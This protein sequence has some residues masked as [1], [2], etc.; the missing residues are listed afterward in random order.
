M[1]TKMRR[2]WRRSRRRRR[3]GGN[4]H[5]GVKGAENVIYNNIY[6]FIIAK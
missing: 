6:N 1:K 5:N 2:W 4:V 3:K